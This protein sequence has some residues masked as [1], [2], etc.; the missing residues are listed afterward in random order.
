MSEIIPA[1]TSSSPA[2]GPNCPSDATS[3]SVT[4]PNTTNNTETEPNKRIG[5]Y[6]RNNE[7]DID[8]LVNYTASMPVSH[9]PTTGRVTIG[10]LSKAWRKAKSRPTLLQM[11]DDNSNQKPVVV[12]E[13]SSSSL[14][15]KVTMGSR[16]SRTA[17]NVPKGASDDASK[18]SPNNMDRVPSLSWKTAPDTYKGND[19]DTLLSTSDQLPNYDS[20]DHST[21]DES[22]EPHRTKSGELIQPTTELNESI[23]RS[24]S[25]TH[26]DELTKSLSGEKPVAPTIPLTASPT[27]LTPT[28]ALEDVSK[29][30]AAKIIQRYYRL[31]KMRNHFKSIKALNSPTRAS[32]T[33]SIILPQNRSIVS[34]KESSQSEMTPPPTPIS[35]SLASLSVSSTMQF[36]APSLLNENYIMPFI[37][38]FNSGEVKCVKKIIQDLTP[39][40]PHELIGQFLVKYEN[41]LDK[42][43]IGELLG[44][45]DELSIKIM[46]TYIASMDF[47]GID[48]DMALRRLLSRFR[49][50]GEAQKIDRILNEFAMCYCVH[51]PAVFSSP[52]TAYI[53]SFSLIMLNTDAHN[54]NVKKKMSL[55]EFMR[56]NRGIDDNK[57]LPESFLRRLYYEIVSNEIKMNDETGVKV[58]EIVNRIVGR[59]EVLAYVP[60]RQYIGEFGAQQVQNLL[61]P[62]QQKHERT[63]FLFSDVILITKPKGNKRYHY[64]CCLRLEQLSWT[65][66]EN[67]FHPHLIQLVFPSADDPKR[68]DFY[69]LSFSNPELKQVF[70]KNL[71]LALEELKQEKLRLQKYVTERVQL[72]KSKLEMAYSNVP[73]TAATEFDTRRNATV[74]YSASRNRNDT[75]DSKERL[76]NKYGESG[77]KS[78]RVAR[79]NM[80]KESVMTLSAVLQSRSVIQQNM[81]NT[82]NAENTGT[83]NGNLGSTNL[84]TSGNGGNG[85]KK[86]GETEGT[87]TTKSNYA[88][89]FGTPPTIQIPKNNESSSSGISEGFGWD[90][91]GRL[92]GELTWGKRRRAHTTT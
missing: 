67:Q 13:K 2:K 25:L 90:A 89:T 49:L 38:A 58:Q 53:L 39:E 78:L 84:N 1:G 48:F 76:L 29:D 31:Y 6:D 26:L 73:S 60:G 52:V 33:H 18:N 72:A 40:S 37:T 55:L 41:K 28:S 11:A 7:G 46:K 21:E 69:H 80:K 77:S 51:N 66:I 20:D 14:W 68:T 5:P 70:L 57:D 88:V 92:A 15:D 62:S 75:L 86:E 36:I 64:R 19:I 43:K 27:K 8:T 44:Q 35:P 79:T 4:S 12:A 17:I 10:S 9:S 16:Q 82:A 54:P 3:S 23:R 63:V 87:S 45:P 32:P 91:L 83:S 65:E 74:G 85:D 71:R 24:K 59:R 22:E 50:P 56:N 61:R 47:R 30:E 34:I 42:N 81:A